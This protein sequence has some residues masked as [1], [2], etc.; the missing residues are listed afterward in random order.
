M[1]SNMNFDLGIDIR[2]LRHITY[3]YY[4]HAIKKTCEYMSTFMSCFWF[5][6]IDMNVC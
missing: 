1:L 6:N 5:Q 2:V 4:V 3:I